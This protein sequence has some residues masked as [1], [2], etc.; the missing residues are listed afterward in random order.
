MLKENSPSQRYISNA[1]NCSS[2]IVNKIVNS[3]L[4]LEKAKQIMLI[5]FFRVIPTNVK[6]ATSLFMKNIYLKKSGIML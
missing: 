2:S 3:D 4:N 5:V 1:L 6:H